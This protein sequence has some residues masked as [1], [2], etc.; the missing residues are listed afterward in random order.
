MKR[1]AVMRIVAGVVV[2]AIAL[3]AFD[4]L[5]FLAFSTGI[6]IGFALA[7]WGDDE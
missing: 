6:A 7:P 4:P 5:T 2:Y 3:L 1:G